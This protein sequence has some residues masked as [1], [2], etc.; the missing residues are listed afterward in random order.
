M[1]W[2]TITYNISGSVESVTVNTVEE[3]TAKLDEI[4]NTIDYWA[5]ATSGSNE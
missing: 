4:W 1:N 2:W 3:F 5:E